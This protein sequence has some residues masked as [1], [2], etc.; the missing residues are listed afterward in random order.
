LIIDDAKPGEENQAKT[1]KPRRKIKTKGKVKE[2][3]PITRKYMLDELKIPQPELVHL[4]I[5]KSPCKVNGD[6]AYVV[7]FFNFDKAGEKGLKIRD[8]DSLNE[9]PELVEYEGYY[10]RE[11]GGQIIVKRCDCSEKSF[12]EERAKNLVVTEIG[13][14]NEKAIMQN[15]IS[16]VSKSKKMGGV[17]VVLVV[18]VIVALVFSFWLK[19]S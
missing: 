1:D 15:W 8:Y 2:V 16:S 5:A 12:L 11:K 6:A 3:E 10:V 18:L 17:V 7:R 19:G 9:H 14:E 13:V 4:R